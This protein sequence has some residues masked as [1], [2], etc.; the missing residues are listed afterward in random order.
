MSPRYGT[1]LIQNFEEVKEFDNQKYSTSTYF[2]N[3]P[4]E[5][6]A[7]IGIKRQLGTDLMTVLSAEHTV[8]A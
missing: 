7:V 1:S 5:E 4:N 6:W 8:R 2:K 3:R